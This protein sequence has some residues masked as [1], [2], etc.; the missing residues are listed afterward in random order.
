MRGHEVKPGAQQK[1]TGKK[2]DCE[3]QDAVRLQG[4]SSLRLDDLHVLHLIRAHQVVGMGDAFLG[5]EAVAL[6]E[7]TVVQPGAPEVRVLGARDLAL[8]LGDLDLERPRHGSCLPLR[9]SR[10][11]IHRSASPHSQPHGAGTRPKGA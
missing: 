10:R 11:S 8:R 3:R 6:A 4:Q 7:E 1:D 5:A 9:R 2:R